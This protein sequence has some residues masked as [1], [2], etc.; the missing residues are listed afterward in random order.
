MA[1]TWAASLPAVGANNGGDVTLTFSNFVNAA[2]SAYTLVTGDIV[3]V[4]YASSGTA[5][6]AMAA[7]WSGGAGDSVTLGEH[8]VDGT[9]DTNLGVF[10]KTMGATPDASVVVTGPTGNSSGTIAVA[11]VIKGAVISAL[12]TAAIT[13]GTTG[14][15]VPNPGSVLPVTAGAFIA[16]VGAGAAAAGATFTPN[17]DLNTTTNHWRTGNHAETNDIAIGFGWK[18]DW[19]SGAFDPGVWTGGNVN[20]SNTWAALT[21]AIKPKPATQDL[22]PA[23]FTNTQTFH[24][25]ALSLTINAGLFTN[26]QTLYGP[27]VTTGPVALTP[28]LFTNT[29]TFH[30]PTLLATYGLTP[31]LFTNTQTFYSPTVDAGVGGQTLEPDLFTNTQSFFSATVSASYTLSP[32]LLTN[33]QTFYGPELVQG[34]AILAPALF[35]NEQTFY[36]PTLWADVAG[37]S[38]TWTPISP[39]SASYAGTTAASVT[40]TPLSSTPATWS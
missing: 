17:A 11:H 36:G 10:A 8:Y 28:D 39:T 5:N 31:S 22:T 25:P 2:G 30:A 35:A 18:E 26:S 9:I 33:T 12:D 4:A 34:A 38:G 24:A 21:L 1:I 7:T 27:T 37:G 40:W 16:V 23:L 15:T 29:Q 19:A 3:V 14:T 20:A 6:L 13:A 32:A